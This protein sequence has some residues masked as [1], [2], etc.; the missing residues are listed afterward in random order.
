M[1]SLEFACVASSQNGLSSSK[2][3]CAAFLRDQVR[4]KSVRE[5]SC[6]FWKGI[7][8]KKNSIH[9]WYKLFEETGRI[10][11]GKTPRN[12]QSLKFW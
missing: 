3:L 12:D 11:E 2:S 9:T 10:C 5:I 1:A 6:C 7:T 8:T 4:D